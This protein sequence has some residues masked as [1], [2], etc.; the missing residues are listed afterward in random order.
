VSETG[1]AMSFIQK[2][3]LEWRS[4]TSG[5]IKRPKAAPHNTNMIEKSPF[6]ALLG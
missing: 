6:A 4:P 3:P 5:D 1:W 2:A